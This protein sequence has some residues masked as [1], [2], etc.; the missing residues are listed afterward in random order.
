MKFYADTEFNG[1]GGE[2]ISLALIGEDGSLFYEAMW[3]E[4][5]VPW[6]RDNVMPH[7]PKDSAVT[8]SVFSSRLWKF[9]NKHAHY[10]IICD[11]PEDIVHICRSIVTGPGARFSTGKLTFE[12]YTGSKPDSDVPHHALHDALALAK[13][14]TGREV[15]K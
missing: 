15:A 5:P 8:K 12:L 4:K 13:A 1:F 6:V 3:C 11:W 10:H 7:I 14:C 2:L 9:L